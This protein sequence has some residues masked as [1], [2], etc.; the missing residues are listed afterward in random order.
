MQPTVQPPTVVTIFREDNAF[1][2]PVESKD[3]INEGRCGYDDSHGLIPCPDQSPCCGA[4]GYC[5]GGALFCG[6]GCLYGKCWDEDSKDDASPPMCGWQA[7]GATCGGSLCCSEHGYCGESYEYCSMGCQS[8][9]CYENHHGDNIMA[10]GGEGEEAAKDMLHGTGFGDGVGMYAV[11]LD[12]EEI[13]SNDEF[14][15]SIDNEV[16]V[17]YQYALNTEPDANLDEV[18]TLAELQLHNL[19]IEEKMDCSQVG[20]RKLQGQTEAQCYPEAVVSSPGEVELSNTVCQE[21]EAIEG[22]NCHVIEGGFGLF[23]GSEGGCSVSAEDYIK[24]QYLMWVRDKMTE[25]SRTS[26]VPVA[27]ENVP[28]AAGI[29]FRGAR[30]DEYRQPS[31]GGSASGFKLYNTGQ[32]ED[33]KSITS[34]GSKCGLHLF[35][36]STLSLYCLDTNIT[37]TLSPFSL[38]WSYIF[39]TVF[40]IGFI[41]SGTIMIAYLVTKAIRQSRRA[42]DEDEEFML[43]KQESKDL[44]LFDLEGDVNTTT[45]SSSVEPDGVNPSP[46]ASL[47]RVT[48]VPV[49]DGSCNDGGGLNARLGAD[50]RFPSRVNDGHSNNDGGPDNRLGAVLRVLS[51]PNL[52]DKALDDADKSHESCHHFP[53]GSSSTDKNKP[54][55]CNS[56]L[57]EICCGTVATPQQEGGLCCAFPSILSPSARNSTLQPRSYCTPDTI[58]F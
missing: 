50:P 9:E 24:Q 35:L 36:S 37:C 31:V 47:Q 13:A 40:F 21:S 16:I 17:R 54:H 56:Q 42:P 49:D 52:F 4:S 33:E 51:D 30:S 11:C 20:R 12:A 53:Q 39:R 2:E 26:G 6:S 48:F 28:G 7:D 14:G 3:D 23:L 45:G 22:K 25:E 15:A 1:D 58:E 38:K 18:L 34:V 55:F 5:G 44:S 27:I 19:L 41:C 10:I 46:T 43:E 8:G 57:C 29:S 32:N